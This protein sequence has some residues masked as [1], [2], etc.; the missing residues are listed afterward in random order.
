MIWF[1]LTMTEM[2]EGQCCK[3][4]VIWFSCGAPQKLP[5]TSQQLQQNIS[6]CSMKAVKYKLQVNNKSARSPDGKLYIV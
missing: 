6:K 3:Y 4:Q 2:E 5:I 1:Y